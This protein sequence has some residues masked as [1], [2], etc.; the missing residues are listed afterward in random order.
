MDYRHFYIPD[1]IVFITQVV[2]QR[3]PV[4]ANPD[5]V[6]LLQSILHKVQE[7]HPFQMLA[8]VFLPDHFHLLIKPGTAINHS[9][10]MH[11]LKPN[12]TKAY[13]KACHTAGP[14][15]FWQRRY[16]TISFTMRT[17]FSAI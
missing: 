1:S 14:M 12:F 2:Y 4:F 5:A 17:I 6:T 16:W 10:I 9:E 15:C 13:K 3:E 11:S 7:L 8:Y